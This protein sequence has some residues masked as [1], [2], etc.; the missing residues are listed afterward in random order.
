MP[1]RTTKARPVSIGAGSA[2][3]KSSGLAVVAWPDRFAAS[4]PS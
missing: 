2:T 1:F 4:A 3:V